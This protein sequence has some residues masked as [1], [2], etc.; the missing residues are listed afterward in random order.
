M[1]FNAW[2]HEIFSKID[3]HFTWGLKYG[4]IYFNTDSAD[5]MKMIEKSRNQKLRFLIRGENLNGFALN[6][7]FY[8]P[9]NFNKVPSLR[10]PKSYKVH[11]LRYPS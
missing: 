7:L 9:M 6:K 2:L 1:N 10:G 11:I 3:E 5:F 4:E 8:D